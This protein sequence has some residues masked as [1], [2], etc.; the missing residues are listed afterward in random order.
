[1]FNALAICDTVGSLLSLFIN[2]SLTCNALYAI[3]LKDLLTLIELLSL[4][5]LL[6]SPI[7]IGTA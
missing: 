6:I 3:S 7:I 1:M 4:K 5:Y 2:L